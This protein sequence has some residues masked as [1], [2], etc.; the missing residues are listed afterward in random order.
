MSSA[1]RCK[2]LRERQREGRA[3]LHVEVDLFAHTEML[4]AA[5]ALEQWDDHDRDAIARATE[6]LLSALAA[7]ADS[8]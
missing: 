3:L 8:A 4:V 7:E 1:A 6:R 2:R 5:G